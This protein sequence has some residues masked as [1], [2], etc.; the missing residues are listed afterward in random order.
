M[1]SE[2]LCETTKIQRGFH[3]FPLSEVVVLLLYVD[4]F[5]PFVETSTSQTGTL[6]LSKQAMVRFLQD[7]EQNWWFKEHG[8][9][10]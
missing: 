1:N 7:E 2:Q 10:V 3:S 8:L 9:V 4:E 6:N 5:K